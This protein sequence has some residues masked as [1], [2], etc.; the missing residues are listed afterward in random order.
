MTILGDD[1]ASINSQK[2]EIW[3]GSIGQASPPSVPSCWRDL[4]QTR[5]TYQSSCERASC[6]ALI[7]SG[8]TAGYSHEAN[9]DNQNL[10]PKC[11]CDKKNVRQKFDIV[12]SF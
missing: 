11:K 6:G 10:A 9:C 12:K 5:H 8:S 4:T 1:D 7:D 3:E 2:F